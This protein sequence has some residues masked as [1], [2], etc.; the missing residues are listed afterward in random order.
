MTCQQRKEQI[1]TVLAQGDAQKAL[2]FIEQYEDDYPA[3]IDLISMKVNLCILIGDLDS[4][5]S[6]AIAGVQ[7]LPLN[8][9]LYYNLA[10]VYEI[11]EDYLNAYI[12]YAKAFI[13][14]KNIK[15][16][17]KI[18]ELKVD[19]KIQLM[20]SLINKETSYIKDEIELN[21]REEEIKN[22]S[23]MENCDFGFREVTFRGGEKIVGKYYYES[24]YERRFVGVYK[25]QFL[26]IYGDFEQNMD[27]LH[28][29]GEFLKVKDGN[30]IQLALG[31]D[32]ETE[33][34][35]PIASSQKNTLHRF[36]IDDKSYEIAQYAANHFN[37]YRIKG[38]M[39]VC[40]SQ[41]S[42]YGT[43][44]PLK[45]NSNNKK[46]VLS[47]FL[48][49]ASQCILKGEN[50][51][52]NMP[53]TYEYF[54]KGTI[55]NRAY[56]TAEWTYP[57]IVN[58]VTGLDTTH[59]MAFHNKLDVAMPRDIPTLAEYFHKSGYYTANFGGNWRIIPP[60][61]H[62]RGYDRFIYQH[63]KAGFKVQEA[64]SEAINH[65]EMFKETDQYLWLSIG[66]LHDIADQDDLPGDV[67][68]DLPLEMRVYENNGE[69][70]VK[71]GYSMNKAENYIREARHID[72]WLHILYNY[73]EENFMEEDIVVSLFADHGQGYLVNDEKA[74]FLSDER[75]NVAFMFRGGAAEG[76]G[77]IDEIIST[78]DYSSIMR[79]LAGIRLPEVP[80][81][82]RLPKAFGGEA[83]RDY[84][85]TES[86]HPHDYYR[87]AFFAKDGTFVFENPYPVEDD[88][89]FKLA[90]YSYWMEDA[91]GRKQEDEQQCKMYL[92]I[93]MDH[94]APLL[95]YE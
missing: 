23:I 65:L 70:S 21:K 69:T 76:Q 67:Q 15:A 9:D 44:I 31:T 80:T 58:Y 85:L 82:G 84:A 40:S 14:Y 26:S 41:L 78:S 16:E 1:E 12:N 32:L 94:I 42:Y 49:G 79:S 54:R 22:I 10:I 81:D 3:D 57:S 33:F 56:N 88:G 37:Y 77:V 91:E 93:L 51:K 63:Q 4:A 52:K 73:L 60:Y 28:L 39:E 61:G 71:Q 36:A 92:K 19:E 27:V 24:Q 68:K 72:R 53:Y 45:H 30:H 38:N 48:D 25:D 35:L 13:I 89:R 43:P 34:L 95:I 64:V 29:K 8:G 20:V 2:T 66:D 6:F 17:K 11:L 55:C 50:F 59:H 74:H 46:L 83:E 18:T 62:A 47:L 86:I 90:D 5:L 75:S 87:A 7:R